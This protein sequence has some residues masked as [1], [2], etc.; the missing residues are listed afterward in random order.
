MLDLYKAA[1]T[2]LTES[3]KILAEC[4][5]SYEADAYNH[6]WTLNQD[7]WNESSRCRHALQLH[8]AEHGC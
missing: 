5:I 2:K 4:A 3:G 1:V 6:A 7:A 8:M